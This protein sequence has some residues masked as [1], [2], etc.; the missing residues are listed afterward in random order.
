MAKMGYAAVG[1]GSSDAVLGDKYYEKL[2]ANHLA[3][4]DTSP[5]ANKSAVPFLLKVVGGVK[6]G[7][8]SFGVR[9]S[10]VIVDDMELRKMRFAALKD[11]RAKSDVLILLDQAGIATRDWID[12]NGPRIGAPD[13]VI[14]GINNGNPSYSEE[15]IGRAHIMPCLPQAKELGVI[16][17]EVS[18]NVEP[19]V[20]LTR[21][22]LNEKIAEDP[23]LLKQINDANQAMGIAPAGDNYVPA[24]QVG[25]VPKPTYS[26]KLCKA[27]H[28]KQYEDWSQT[29]HAKAL[30]TL[31][32][33]TRTTPD[34]LPCHSETYRAAR[35]YSRPDN[36]IGGV[37]CA[38]CHADALPHGMERQQM[39][40]HSKVEPALCLQCH[41]KERSPT[42]DEKTYFPRVV[43]AGVM[44]P[45]TA[46]VPSGR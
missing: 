4:V 37:E 29:K 12:R 40:T 44:G 7:I 20:A 41:T 43:H 11:A 31:V 8:L 45:A 24:N 10:G 39:A 23:D 25:F 15:V 36:G 46:S 2:A 42:Y 9:P 38:T 6:V 1:V 21:L 35:Q 5:V 33:A 3:V 17:L 22:A 13:I 30:Q 19:K 28:L 26:P 18:P 27:C 16:D 32:D 34:C 14:G